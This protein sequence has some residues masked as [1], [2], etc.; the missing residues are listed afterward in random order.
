MFCQTGN[1]VGNLDGAS[2]PVKEQ[3]PHAGEA[4]QI[5]GDGVRQLVQQCVEGVRSPGF[6]QE[7]LKLFKVSLE[8]RCEFDVVLGG[9]DVSRVLIRS[10][11]QRGVA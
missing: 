11:W 4:F 10:P 1:A 9:H 7:G 8:V 2:R 5:G 3:A 6:D